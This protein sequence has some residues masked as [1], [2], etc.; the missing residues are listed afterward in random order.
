MVRDKEVECQREHINGILGRPLNSSCL[1]E[2]FSVV[3]SI[4]DLKGWLAPMIFDVTS[5]CIGV[6]VP[7]EK[8]SM[9]IASS[10]WF[11]FISR[12]IM[13]SHNKSFLHLAKKAFLGF[14]MSRRRIDLGLLISQNMALKPSRSWLLYPSRFWWLN[15]NQVP[16]FPGHHEEYWGHP[17]FV[18]WHM[19]YRGWIHMRWG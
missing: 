3:P 7:I 15:C 18:H 10:F 13:P 1:Y 5:K 17:V 19:A 6:W 11:V 2:G 16:E 4:N 14:I 9:N 8:R 12:S